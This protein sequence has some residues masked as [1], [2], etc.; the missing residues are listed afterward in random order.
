MKKYFLLLSIIFV[1]SCDSEED[2]AGRFFIKGNEAL[3]NGQYEQA[4]RFY[5]EALA[6]KPNYK[7]ALNNRGVAL[8]QNGRYTE[9]II[10]YSNIL[11]QIDTA[12]TDALRNRA[13]AYLADGRYDMALEDLTKLQKT[14]PDSAYVY[15]TQGIA[16]HESGSYAK[17]IEAFE[18]S[19]EKD[20]N[21]AEALVNAANSFFMLKEIQ[22]AEDLLNKAEGLDATEPNIYNTRGMIAMEMGNLSEAQKW[23]DQALKM[24]PGNPYYFNNRGF[25]NLQMNELEAAD[26]DIRRA[27]IGAPENAWAYRN[28]GILFLKRQ[29]YDDA[30]RNFEQANKLNSSIPLLHFFWAQTLS[31][32]GKKLEACGHLAQ[33]VEETEE[34]EALK[35]SVCN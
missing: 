30:L 3:N 10:D 5:T 16:L 18:Q 4:I 29:R 14:Y 32:Q 26:E 24:D 19:M 21:D 2:K 1:F 17:A 27:I 33:E 6:I 23:F 11:V 13:N 9:A 12:Y 15:F 22:K 25:L 7:E 34:I 31:I 28:R 20:P 35:R 8:Y